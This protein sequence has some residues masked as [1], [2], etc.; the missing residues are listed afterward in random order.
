MPFFLI[1]LYLNT[2]ICKFFVCLSPTL[3]SLKTPRQ[4]SGLT[5]HHCIVLHNPAL[6]L[7]FHFQREEILSLLTVKV[8]WIRCSLPR[9]CHYMGKILHFLVFVLRLL[10]VPMLPL[11][12]RLAVLSTQFCLFYLIEH[13]LENVLNVITFLFFL[14]V[15]FHLRKKNHV[16]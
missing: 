16:P 14:F 5:N 4:M 12:L 9:Q 7:I 8:N 6:L 2:K 3:Q 10:V 15:Y 11:L 1:L 13:F